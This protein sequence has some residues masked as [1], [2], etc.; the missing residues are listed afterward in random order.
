MF[1]LLIA[2]IGLILL[3]AWLGDNPAGWFLVLSVVGIFAAVAFSM[4][5][6]ELG[7]RVQAMDNMAR[8][9]RS[10][11]DD[12][13]PIDTYLSLEPGEIAFY[14]RG[15]VLLREYKSSGSTYSG[16]FGG[17]SYRL[18][19]NLSVGGGGF[20]GK[21]IRNP[22]EATTID[23]GNAIFTNRR[24]VFTG[25]NHT[26]EFDLDKLLN[27]DFDEN[28]FEVR[29]AVSGRQK[30]SALAGDS[31]F[32]ITPG[33]AFQLA[34]EFNREGEGAAKKLAGQMAS[35]IED[36]VLEYRRGKSS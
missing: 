23:T 11:E 10:L 14:E 12:F 4:R 34:A 22:E 31:A 35:D 15:N 30:T 25:P 3:L 26:R 27:L 32:G 2:V 19:Q 33:I 1:Y 6:A 13:G 18:T 9:L 5:K 16:G 20:G 36:Q 7:R 8:D 24:V 28:G 29:A 21:S 17:A